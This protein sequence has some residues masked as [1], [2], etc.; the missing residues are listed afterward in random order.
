[1]RIFGDEDAL[2]KSKTIYDAVSS[3]IFIFGTYVILKIPKQNDFNKKKDD[4]RLPV[5]FHFLS[6]FYFQIFP[7]TS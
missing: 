4:D 6:F 1:M 7:L 3:K 5:I 2:S